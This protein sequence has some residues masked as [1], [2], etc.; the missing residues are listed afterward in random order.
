MAQILAGVCGLGFWCGGIVHVVVSALVVWY[1]VWG[2]SDVGD[3]LGFGWVGVWL[4]C[5]VALFLCCVLVSLVGSL[6]GSL[7]LWFACLWVCVIWLLLVVV[8]CLVRCGF[9]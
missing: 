3:I 9:R 1:C 6:F 5:F 2:I 8:L 4:M 7:S